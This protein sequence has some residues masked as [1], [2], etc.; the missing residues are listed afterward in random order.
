MSVGGNKEYS[1]KSEILGTSSPPKLQSRFT[2]RTSTEIESA[3]STFPLTAWYIYLKRQCLEFFT[4]LLD[5]T[6]CERKYFQRGSIFFFFLRE[7]RI[8]LIY[9]MYLKRVFHRLAQRC[10]IVRHFRRESIFFFFFFKR[11]FLIYDIWECLE[12]FTDLF[13]EYVAV[14][15]VKLFDSLIY[16]IK[17]ILSGVFQRLAQRVYSRLKLLKEKYSFLSF[18][19]LE[20]ENVF[21]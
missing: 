1:P 20:N 7:C 2:L 4:G 21:L 3:S 8:S 10:A 18:F 11:I 16:L 14:V 5:V 13:N 15:N 19:F 17:E 9:Y 12:F 6:V